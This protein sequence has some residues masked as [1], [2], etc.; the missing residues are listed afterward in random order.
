MDTGFRKRSCSNNNVER[1][2]DSKKSHLALARIRSIQV[3]YPLA[4]VRTAEASRSPA[5]VVT[6]GLREPLMMQAELT[7]A[8]QLAVDLHH[9]AID[10]SGDARHVDD[11]RT[12]HV[13]D[14]GRR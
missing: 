4:R 6:A 8:L 11:K 9:V 2:G 14:F 12:A 3:G 13:R 7:Q 1:D 5:S 10:A